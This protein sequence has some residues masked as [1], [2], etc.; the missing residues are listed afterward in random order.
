[1][2]RCLIALGLEVEGGGLPRATIGGA[3]VI[4]S[5]GVLEL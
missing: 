3:A 2:D 1:M 5:S 4:V